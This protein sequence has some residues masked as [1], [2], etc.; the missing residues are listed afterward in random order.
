MRWAVGC[1]SAEKSIG[2]LAEF[3]QKTMQSFSFCL[4]F[5][6]RRLMMLLLCKS[7]ESWLVLYKAS[8]S[9]SYVTFQRCRTFR[10]SLDLLLSPNDWTMELKTCNRDIDGDDVSTLMI[11]VYS[12]SHEDSPS[13]QLEPLCLVHACGAHLTWRCSPLKSIWSPKAFHIFFVVL[14]FTNVTNLG[15]I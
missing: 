15:L 7:I 2:S 4:F 10:T 11:L 13:G 9:M 5:F 3:L 6:A 1:L 12:Q 8:W 14:L